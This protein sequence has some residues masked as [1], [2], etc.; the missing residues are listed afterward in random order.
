MG[1]NRECVSCEMKG[2]RWISG[3]CDTP[4]EDNDTESGGGSENLSGE[5]T[6]R[7]VR[8]QRWMETGEPGKPGQGV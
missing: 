6:E 7:V 1:V 8:V 5:W 2:I 3:E 4:E